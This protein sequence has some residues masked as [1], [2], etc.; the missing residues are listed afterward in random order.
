MTGE[1]EGS[2][3]PTPNTVPKVNST[4]GRGRAAVIA[5][6][7]TVPL[8]VVLAFAF[9]AGKGDGNGT[10]NS[11]GADSTRVLSPV[12]A[13]AIP[14]NPA[15]DPGCVKV[16]AKLPVQLGTLAP[17]VAR[18]TSTFVAA[19]GDPAVI[20]RCGVP[21]PGEL[22][23]GNADLVLDIGTGAGA[24]TE[25]LPKKTS[26]GT[27]F[28]TIDR[29]VYV[30]VFVPGELQSSAPLP[31]LSQA[32]AAALPAVCQ[33]Q[34]NPYPTNPGPELQKTLCVYRR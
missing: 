5:T 4:A 16:F 15:A 26:A 2:P 32:I 34:P 29:S 9:T 7:I 30:E 8:V 17:R 25:W 12:T 28:T 3:R 18:A 1:E 11:S 21:R 33:A 19:W 24:T 6:A 31:G 23:P 20:L 27:Y 10:A 13:A 22:I 14:P